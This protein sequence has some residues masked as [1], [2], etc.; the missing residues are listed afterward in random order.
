MANGTVWYS[1]VQYSIRWSLRI[2]TGTCTI[3]EMRTYYLDSGPH[4]LP[5]AWLISTNSV[6][7]YTAARY[8][9]F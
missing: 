9:D 5:A 1:T 2:A 7:F 4:F 3:S 8:S 6:Y